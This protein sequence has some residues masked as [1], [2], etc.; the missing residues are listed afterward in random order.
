MRNG[1]LSPIARPAG[2]ADALQVKRGNRFLLCAVACFSLGSCSG[3]TK[4]QGSCHSVGTRL[5]QQELHGV[6]YGSVDAK[7]V[8]RACPG[9]K[10]PFAFIGDA[11][12]DYGRLQRLAAQR[13]DVVGFDAIA[14]GYIVTDGPGEYVLL[15]ITLERVREDRSVGEAARAAAR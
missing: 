7:A 11:P 9:V 8:M 14:D 6:I 13:E 2:I 15:L 10:L 12:A 1:C 4:L 3:E 5:H